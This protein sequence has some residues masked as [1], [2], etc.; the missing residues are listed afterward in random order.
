MRPTKQ[1]RLRSREPARPQARR[2]RAP[3]P[4]TL[5]QLS[6]TA[7]MWMMWFWMP[8]L[9]DRNDGVNSASRPAIEAPAR[10]NRV[11]LAAPLVAL[12]IIGALAAAWPA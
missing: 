2:A 4:E 12:V 9:P 11:L 3:S 5:A 10:S 1:A 6:A 8:Q 7:G